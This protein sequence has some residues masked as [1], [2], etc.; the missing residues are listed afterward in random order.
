[1]SQAMHAKAALRV[2]HVTPEVAPWL[3]TGGLGLV[4]GELPAAQRQQGLDAY[5]LAPLYGGIDRN[6]LR[7]E[8]RVHS[9]YLQG[10][11]YDYRLWRSRDGWL[12]FADVPGLLDRPQPYG[13]PSTPYEDNPLRFAVFSKIAAQL[14]LDYDVVHLH[15]WPAALTALYLQGARPTVQTVHNLAYQGQ[16]HLGW[17]HSLEIPAELQDWRGVEYYGELSLLKAGLV[18]ADRLSTVSPTYA[19]EIQDEPGGRGL[20]GLFRHRAAQLTGILNGLDV[21]SRDPA[22]DPAL[23]APYRAASAH[24]PLLPLPGKQRCAEALRA[25]FCLHEGPIFGYVGRAAAQ[26]GLDLLAEALPSLLH[27][28][29]NVVVLA[30]GDAQILRALQ[31]YAEHYP[32]RVAVVRA[33]QPELS[34][35]IYAASDFNLVPSRFEPCGLSQLIGMRYGAV[36]IARRTGGL[37]DTVRHGETGLVFEAASAEALAGSLRQAALLWHEAPT[38]YLALQRRAMAQDWSWDRSARRY[39]E[40]IYAP[41]AQREAAAPSSTADA[42]SL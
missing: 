42:R 29:A 15:D 4:L 3:S 30:D 32:Q 6:R 36:P 39:L 27:L 28:G 23:P 34:R 13:P 12:T 9:V 16:C 8:L 5:V 19:Q 40:Q 10:Q 2:L 21:R 14:A 41:L 26:K 22:Q 1:M 20:S 35:Q 31:G 17:A 11:R 38:E 24:D 25:R 7:P 33:F 18:C 37:A